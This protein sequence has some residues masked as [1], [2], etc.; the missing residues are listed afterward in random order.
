MPGVGW[1]DAAFQEQQRLL[2]GSPGTGIVLEPLLTELLDCQPNAIFLEGADRHHL[3]IVI[4]VDRSVARKMAIGVTRKSR[5]GL[6]FETATSSLSDHLRGP[7]GLNPIE[8][9]RV[10]ELQRFWSAF[11][12][13]CRRTLA[14][15]RD[16]PQPI[17]TRQDDFV[18][19]L[20]DFSLRS[21]EQSA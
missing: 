2:A 15:Q 20:H 19:L 3:V 16:G 5:G 12:L 8:I 18:S 17:I 10:S 13:A 14:M 6:V 7:D 9:L 4:V 21:P 11:G 1:L